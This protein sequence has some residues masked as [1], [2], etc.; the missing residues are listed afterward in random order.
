MFATFL[1]FIIC[2][3]HAELPAW[4]L[5]SVSLAVGIFCG[6]LTMF[7]IYCGLFLGGFGLGFFI[8]LAIFFII[9]TFL[10]VSI[11]WIPFGVLLGLSVIFGLLALRWQKGLFIVATCLI[12][13]ALITGGVDYFIEEFVLLNYAWQRIMAG[14]GGMKCWVTWVI[15]AIWP[16]MFILGIVVQFCKTGRTFTHRKSK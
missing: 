4:G 11:K 1:T 8:G 13:G 9:E 2:S 12:G 3:N 10:H 5:I 6:L 15:V 14:D 7:V 16:V